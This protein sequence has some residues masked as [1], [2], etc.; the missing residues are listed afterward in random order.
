MLKVSTR[1]RYGIW[2]LMELALAG[3]NE[4]LNLHTIS[5]KQ[6]ISYKYLESIFK[7]LRKSNLVRSTRGA[8]GGYELV[9]KA[10]E[11]TMLEIVDT[12]EGPLGSVPCSTDPGYC[13]SSGACS[14]RDFF[15][16]MDQ[17]IVHFLKSKN[18]EWFIKKNARKRERRHK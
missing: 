5:K 17:E 7:T 15:K 3:E 1:T 4:R 18:L 2:A 16:E 13:K 6:K 14:M 12:L 11:L 10:G 8:D 9:K